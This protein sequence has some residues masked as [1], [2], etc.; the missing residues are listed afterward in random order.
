MVTGS[1]PVNPTIHFKVV[2]RKRIKSFIN[3][4]YIE[5]RYQA[6]KAK[7]FTTKNDPR[8]KRIVE[9]EMYH[10]ALM[11]ATCAHLDRLPK[12]KPQRLDDYVDW[13]AGTIPHDWE[14]RIEERIKTRKE[15]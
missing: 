3:K 4:L 6:W 15:N 12:H 10:R 13:F 9:R 1:S 7:I 2:M 8:V 11:D 5:V 14:N